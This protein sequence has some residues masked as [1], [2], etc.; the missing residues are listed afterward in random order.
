MQITQALLTT[1]WPEGTHWVHM[2]VDDFGN[3]TGQEIPNDNSAIVA[4]HRKQCALAVEGAGDS[5]ADAVQGPIKVLHNGFG[6]L[7]TTTG[8]L[9]VLLCF[10]GILQM[11]T[12]NKL[13][14]QK[15]DPLW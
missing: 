1:H 9:E 13:P 12:H 11:H 6:T 15:K 2:G 14:T 10:Y 8:M 5:D 3:A 7:S 4:A